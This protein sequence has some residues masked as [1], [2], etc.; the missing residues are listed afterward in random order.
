MWSLELA[1]TCH[2]WYPYKKG[3]CAVHEQRK[4]DVR[5]TRRTPRATGGLETQPQLRDPWG[6][7]KE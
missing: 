1:L 2:N 3:K 7:Q 6:Y 5:Y 4:E